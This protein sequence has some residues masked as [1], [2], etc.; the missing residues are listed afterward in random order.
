MKSTTGW[1]EPN[2]GATNESGFSGLPGGSRNVNGNFNNI[3]GNGFWWSSTENDTGNAWYRVLLGS[4]GDAY[5][6]NG[7]KYSGLSCRCLRD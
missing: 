3:G 7:Y 5:R 6:N 1:N 4:Y 2:I